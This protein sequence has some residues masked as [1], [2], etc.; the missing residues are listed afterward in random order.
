MSNQ[1]KVTINRLSFNPEISFW[2]VQIDGTQHYYRITDLLSAYRFARNQSLYKGIVVLELVETSMAK[3]L[4]QLL[5]DVLCDGEPMF[6][7]IKHVRYFED[8]KLKTR[9][10]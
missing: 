1:E 7:R 10:E 4:V 2:R 8:G 5:E 3:T 9:R 6:H